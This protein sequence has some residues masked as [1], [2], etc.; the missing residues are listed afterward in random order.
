MDDRR[1][2]RRGPVLAPALALLTLAGLT[3]L[4]VKAT[5]AAPKEPKEQSRLATHTVPPSIG[6]GPQAV[7]L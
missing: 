1:P 6:R 5:R 3:Y 7:G 2:A 4:S